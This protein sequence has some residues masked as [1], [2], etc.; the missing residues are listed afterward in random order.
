MSHGE[1]IQ[2][3][4]VKTSKFSSQFDSN[5][6]QC[7]TVSRFGVQKKFVWYCE[8]ESN[9]MCSVRGM[10]RLWTKFIFHKVSSYTWLYLE[11][12]TSVSTEKTCAHYFV[13]NACLIVIKVFWCSAIMFIILQYPAVFQSFP[14]FSYCILRL[15]DEAGQIVKHL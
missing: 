5:G 8:L 11:C 9:S 15:L 10:E 1:A 6:I 13:R 14:C 12:L 3:K 7:W 2:P 4:L